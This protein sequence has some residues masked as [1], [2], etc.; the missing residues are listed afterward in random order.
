[1]AQDT[2]MPDSSVARLAELT[3]LDPEGASVRLGFQWAEKPV[4][5]AL[6][7]HFG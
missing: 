4:L 2:C 7:R 6:I 3:V 1:M 5:L